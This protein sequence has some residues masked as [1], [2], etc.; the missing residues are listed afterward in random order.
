[1]TFI[2]QCSRPG[3]GKPAVATLEFNYAEQL[4]IV[5]PLSVSGNPHRWDLC[6]NHARRTTVPQGWTLEFADET[7]AGEEIASEA[8]EEDL[9]ALAE[10]VQ[11]AA[12]H[13]TQAK[14]QPAPRLYR[15]SE[16]P[17]STPHHPSMK[18][19]PRSTPRRHLRAVRDQ[20]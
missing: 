1:M 13:E 17:D 11:Q 9:M 16:I 8:D 14:A 18:N 20:H 4:A 7:T 10:A 3:C 2:R 15:R 6:E 12:E 5:G 19:L